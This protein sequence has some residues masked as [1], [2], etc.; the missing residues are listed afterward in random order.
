MEDTMGREKGGGKGSL[1]VE[2]EN[3]YYDGILKAIC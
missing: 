2:N 1:L 3:D